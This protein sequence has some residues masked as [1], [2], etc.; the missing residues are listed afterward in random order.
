MFFHFHQN[1]SGGVFDLDKENGIAVNVIIEAENSKEANRK[2]SDIGLYF[3]GCQIGIDCP[4]CGDRWSEVWEDEGEEVPLV[5]GTPPQEYVDE[6]RSLWGKK[7]ENV[8]VHYAD[9]RLEV[10]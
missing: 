2:A 6:G 10:F 3:D 4:C 8:A 7:G 9:G 1:N 5:Y